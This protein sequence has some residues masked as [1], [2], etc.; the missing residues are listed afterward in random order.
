MYTALLYYIVGC[1]IWGMFSVE[2]HLRMKPRASRMELFF[3]YIR[4]VVLCPIAFIIY[5]ANGDFNDLFK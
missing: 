2:R 1:C 5:L 3:V 4:N